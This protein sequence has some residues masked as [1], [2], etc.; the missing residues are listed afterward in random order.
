[1]KDRLQAISETALAQ[2]KQASGLDQ[3]NDVRVDFLGKKGQLTALLK[4]MKE[5]APEDRP[6]FGQLVNQTR[7]R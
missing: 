4:S 2:I 6:A 7:E 3:L 5:L 1:M